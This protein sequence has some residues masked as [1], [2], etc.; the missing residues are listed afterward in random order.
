MYVSLTDI[1]YNE[2]VT[3]LQT[4][5]NYTWLNARCL[6]PFAE[7]L[8]ETATKHALNRETESRLTGLLRS[9]GNHAKEDALAL[10][11]HIFRL[12]LAVTAT[13]C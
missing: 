6:F 3:H 5:K 9:H 12:P 13:R 8:G 4:L 7:I 1:A 10:R 2:S 11:K